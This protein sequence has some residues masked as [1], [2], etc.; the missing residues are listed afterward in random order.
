MRAQSNALN[1][2]SVRRAKHNNIRSLSTQSWQLRPVGSYRLELCTCHI[3]GQTKGENNY[4]FL[5]LSFLVFISFPVLPYPYPCF[6]SS[7]LSPSHRNDLGLL[8]Y[9]VFLLSPHRARQLI[10]QKA[11]IRR[12]IPWQLRCSGQQ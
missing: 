9:T 7:F 6:V 5:V 1:T 8:L 2:D 3:F 4:C 11:G 12:D 10:A